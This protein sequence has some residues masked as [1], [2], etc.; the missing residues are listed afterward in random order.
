MDRKVL[1][2]G[3]EALIPIEDQGVRERVQTLNVTQ[4][5][6]SRFQPR[7]TFSSQKIEELAQSIK[8]KGIIQPVI[9][10]TIGPDQYE[11]IAGER[12]LRAAKHL[13]ITEIPAI[14]RRVPD[15]DVLEMSLIENIQREELNAIEEAKAYRRLSHEFGLTQDSIA[16]RVGKDK[17]SVSNLLRLLSLPDKIQNYLLEDFITFGHARAL[18]SL[19]D[20]KRQLSICE[21]VVKKGLSVR[22]VEFLTQR[23]LGLRSAQRVSS[24]HGDHD[25]RNLE[26]KLEQALGTKVRIHHGKK[27]G[28]IEIEYYSLDD[29]DRILKLLRIDN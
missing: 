7:L 23:R 5:H 28:K 8:E 10:R 17:S 24:K 19:Q 14:V 22:Q 15:A 18:L 20:P 4:I 12:R 29:L 3:L 6:P 11:L 2:R 9:V 25:L 21:K 27:R 1:G 13:G 26:R 16:Q